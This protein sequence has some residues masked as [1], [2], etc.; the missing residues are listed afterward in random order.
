MSL[1]LYGF[2]TEFRTWIVHGS[3][4][5]PAQRSDASSRL[6][7]RRKYRRHGNQRSFFLGFSLRAGCMALSYRGDALLLNSRKRK[8]EHCAAAG[9]GLGP[10]AALVRLDDRAADRQAE[11]H[12]LALG[13]HERVEQTLGNVLREVPRRYSLTLISTVAP[14]DATA[15]S[16][17]LRSVAAIASTALRMRLTST[18]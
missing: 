16:I 8:S 17:S 1:L 7:V 13:R 5:H 15:I 10:D 6:M 4:S 11:T 14:V 2:T 18:C 9:I 12:A 3:A